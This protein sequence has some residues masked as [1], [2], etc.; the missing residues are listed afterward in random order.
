MTITYRETIA[1]FDHK[2]ITVDKTYHIARPFRS[3]GLLYGYMDR[4]NVKSFEFDH[5]LSID[6]AINPEFYEYKILG[7]PGA[8]HAG[9]GAT[10]ATGT[11][12]GR[13]AGAA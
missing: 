12:A 13:A 2:R 9:T 1:E 7:A 6:G 11:G 8:D 5:I 3:G 10:G 4:Y